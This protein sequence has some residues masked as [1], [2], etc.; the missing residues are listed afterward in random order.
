MPRVNAIFDP[1]SA[2]PQT[3]VL[4][5]K[6]LILPIRRSGQHVFRITLRVF[7]NRC[8]R[9]ETA[10]A[11]TVGGTLRDAGG[12]ARN[13]K[14]SS[15]AQRVARN[16]TTTTLRTKGLQMG[17]LFD[18]PITVDLGDPLGFG[19]VRT[20]AGETIGAATRRHHALDALDRSPGPIRL[21]VPRQV[22]TLTASF[23]IGLLGRSV[24]H[25]G[26][27][28]A[29]KRHYQLIADADLMQE[30]DRGLTLAS[31]RIAASTPDVRRAGW[32]KFLGELIG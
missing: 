21:I 24:V 12:V 5:V 8:L 31:Q 25:H 27:I 23:A 2:M 10:G 3:A 18:E 14:G 13:G 7:E 32:W 30:I 17:Q 4:F 15:G 22:V 26:G 16:R 1:Y 6:T 9:M 19:L 29:L 28:A 20:L 11:S